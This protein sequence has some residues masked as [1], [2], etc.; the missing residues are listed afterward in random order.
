[1]TSAKIRMDFGEWGQRALS[2][3]GGGE[4]KE[5]FPEEEASKLVLKEWQEL[6][7]STKLRQGKKRQ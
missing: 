5:D 6:I 3:L 7:Q 4:I 1:M 2:L